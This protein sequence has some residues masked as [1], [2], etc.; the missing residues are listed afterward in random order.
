MRK[1]AKTD[2]EIERRS[3]IAKEKFKCLNLTFAYQ[4]LCKFKLLFCALILLT[5]ITIKWQLAS[6][7]TGLLDGLLCFDFG[8]R[9]SPK[10]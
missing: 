3:N 10:L 9:S 1:D 7:L 2:K 6:S 8:A 4:N 5:I